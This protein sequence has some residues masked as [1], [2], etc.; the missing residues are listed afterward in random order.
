MPSS[1]AVVVG[2]Q[3]LRQEMAAAWDAHQAS[4]EGGAEKQRQLVQPR[5]FDWA[6]SMARHYV[7][8]TEEPPAVRPLLL[9]ALMPQNP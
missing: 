5:P 6:A 3:K 7:Y 1:A 8:S 4:P 9:A 2:L